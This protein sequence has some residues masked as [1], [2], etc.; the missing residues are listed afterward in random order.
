[1][2]GLLAAIVDPRLAAIGATQVRKRLRERRVATLRHGIIFVGPL[3][4]PMRRTRSPIG[5]SE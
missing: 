3:S 4:T 5:V 2:Y 1:V